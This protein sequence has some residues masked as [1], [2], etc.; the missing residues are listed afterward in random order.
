MFCSVAFWLENVICKIFKFVKNVSGLSYGQF[1][2]FNIFKNEEFSPILL[3]SISELS[4]SFE[5]LH[6]LV[7]TKKFSLIYI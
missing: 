7:F 5:L 1:S 2:M 4:T 6:N 3:T